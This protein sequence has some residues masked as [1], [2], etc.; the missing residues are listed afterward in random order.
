MPPANDNSRHHGRRTAAAVLPAAKA[1]FN[2]MMGYSFSTI[3]VQDLE[4][5]NALQIMTEF[6]TRMGSNP[7]NCANSSRPMASSTL[8]KYVEALAGDIRSRFGNHQ[9]FSNSPL[10]PTSDINIITAQ[11][12]RD[13]SR[14][15]MNG[16]DEPAMFRNVWPIPRKHG[17]GTH[18]LPFDTAG[19]PNPL[20]ANSAVAMLSMMKSLFRRQ[21]YSS[22]AKL[23]L[24]FNGIGRGGEVKFLTYDKMFF[25][26]NFQMLFSNWFQRKELKTTPTGFTSD[27]VHP[28]LDNLFQLGCYWSLQDGLHRDPAE[29][30]SATGAAQRKLK[31]LFQDLHSVQDGTVAAQITS[32]IRTLVPPQLRDFYSAKSLRAG[33]ITFLSWNASV[34]YQESVALGGWSTGCN[35][36]WYVW[37]YT[38]AI[39]PPVLALAGYP[40]PRVLPKLPTINILF[41]DDNPSMM[42]NPD[43]FGSFIDNLFVISLPEF[44]APHGRLRNLLQVVKVPTSRLIRWTMTSFMVAATAV[45]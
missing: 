6:T 45:Y 31:Y 21:D 22:F 14:V 35:R 19:N 1:L 24:T 15:L 16:T 40:N 37:T 39:V 26:P 42:I 9:A 38:I 30:A 25:C 20:E 36:D 17:P 43:L 41:A 2:R 10:L 28:E 18:L 5:D 11:L 4:G 29:M 33:A 34:T 27:W 23:G 32:V 7:P 8:K 12:E 3:G 13:Q 44:Q